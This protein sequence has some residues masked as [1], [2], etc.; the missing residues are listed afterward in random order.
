MWSKNFRI[1]DSTSTGRRYLILSCIW[2]KKSLI[3]IVTNKSLH[4]IN[5]I[6]GWR[7][8]MQ[9]VPKQVLMTIW[10]GCSWLFEYLL[11]ARWNVSFE[12]FLKV[13]GRRLQKLKGTRIVQINI[14]KVPVVKYSLRVCF[15]YCPSPQIFYIHVYGHMRAF[16][17]YLS[18][19]WLHLHN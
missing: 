13:K 10:T 16:F 18:S 15:I 1:L 14:C 3:S 6:N 12:S 4:E 7:F 8:E 17:K 5:R 9:K 11:F 19:K 2:D